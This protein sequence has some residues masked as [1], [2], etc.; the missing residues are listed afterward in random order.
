MI[1]KKTLCVAAIVETV[2]QASGQTTAGLNGTVTD[3]TGAVLPG[4]KVVVTN[5]DTGAKRDTDTNEAG[6]YQFPILPSGTYSIAVQKDGFKHV[7]QDGIRLE[8]NQVAQLDF[9]MTLGA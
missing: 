6:L 3:S 8:V 1:S 5:I 9:K 4:A 2:W 7:T